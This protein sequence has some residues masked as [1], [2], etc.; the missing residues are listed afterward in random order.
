MKF[1]IL[2]STILAFAPVAAAQLSVDEANARLAERQKAHA[3]AGAATQ[4]ASAEVIELRQVIAELRSENAKLRVEVADLKAQ[5][6][7]RSAIPAA[8]TQPAAKQ[9]PGMITDPAAL[10]HNGMTVAEAEAALHAKFELIESSPMGQTYSARVPGGTRDT[11]VQPAIDPGPRRF[12]FHLPPA[13]RVSQT[14]Y[15]TV[16]LNVQGGKVNNFGCSKDPNG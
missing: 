1:G 6:Q 2:F 15:W 14:W 10:L 13:Q 7:R 12:D 8:A 9:K 5:L 4:P 3:A 11:L 16:T